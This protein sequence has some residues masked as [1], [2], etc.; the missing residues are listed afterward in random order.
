MIVPGIGGGGQLLKE[1][2]KGEI[3][4]AELNQEFPDGTIKI[5]SGSPAPAVRGP[6]GRGSVT[7]G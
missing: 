6:I 3:P 1:N 4:N 7:Y 2:G 5:P